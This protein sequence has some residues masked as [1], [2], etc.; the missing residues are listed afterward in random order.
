MRKILFLFVALLL[1]TMVSIAQGSVKGKLMDSSAKQPLGLATITLF[2]AA[3]TAIIT[4]RLSSADG[5]FKVPGL[6]LNLPLRAIISYSGFEASRHEFTLQNSETLDLGT[7]SMTTTSKTL[8]EVLI[9]SERPPVTVKRDT[10]EFNAS[11]FKTLPTSLVEDLL[12]KLPGIQVDGEG[13]ITANGR[14]VNRIMVDGKAFFGD[15]PKMAT[16]NLPANVIDKV[17]VTEDKDEANRNT[18]GDLTNIGQVINLTLKKGVKKGWFG[19]LYGGG[20]TEER[21][22]AGGIAN[23]YRD[24]MQLSLLAFGNNINRSGFSMKEVQ[25]LGGFN[26]SGYNSMMIMNRGGQTG[27]AINGISFGGI[28]QGISR[29]SGAGFNLNHAPNKKKSFFLQYFYGN[30]KNRVEQLNNLQQF[31]NDTVINNR[32]SSFTNRINNNHNI[33]TGAKLK[34]DTLT[35][36]EFRA[37]YSY[38]S[39]NERTDA[40]VS[41]MNNKTGPVSSGVGSQFNR[42]YVNRYNHNLFITRRSKSKKGRSLNLYHFANYNSNLL[43]FITESDIEELVP[44]YEL[45]EF[46]QLRRQNTPVFSTNTNFSYAEPLG[47]KWTWRIN[48]RYEQTR[49]EQEVGIYDKDLAS[50]KY[51]LIN[52]SKSSGFDRKQ[53]MVSGYTG[54]SYK[55]GKANFTV[56]MKA[57]WQFIDN[58]FRNI[59]DPINHRLFNILPSA[60]FQWKQLSAHYSMNVSAPA[61]NYLMPVPDST[62]PFTIRFGNPYLKPVRQHQINA[63]NFNFLQASGTSYNFWI[64]GSIAE[65]DIVMSRTVAANGIQTDRP[66]NA[67][68][69]AQFWGGIGFGKEFKRNLKFIFSF[70]FSPS[71]NFSR[72]SVIFNNQSSVASTIGGGPGLNI[73]LN[74]NDIIEFRPMYSPNIS[75]TTYTDPRFRNI[76]VVTHYMEGELIV[77]WPKKLVWETNLAYRNANQVAPGLPK[78][79]VLWNAAVTLLMLKG[80]VGLLKLS[81]FDVLDRNKGLQRYTNLNQIV[82]NQTNVLQRYGMLTFTYN[83]RNMGAPKKLGGRDRLFWF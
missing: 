69:S 75:R 49:E 82:D 83:I 65:N 62:N 48:A 66:V 60:S 8:D 32:T 44:V 50:T 73:G 14:R 54:L 26:R 39:A 81:V 70:R 22:E 13:N 53:D 25:D 52:F 61:I 45:R 51:E 18:D 15:D 10:I 4:Y 67:G 72:R 3:D 9:I 31:V 71:F 55:I 12:K 36:I 24:T 56:G 28:D 57:L 23:I 47:T 17:Q 58:E 6:P 1:F 33:S 7:I 29:T 46:N 79:N 20:G 80:D 68:S 11:S 40:V 30:T 35:D 77:R 78:T 38:S 43:R 5:T 63:S 59:P 41:L 27:F 19:K 21:Y 42:F 34:P 2:R 64:N 74:W 37:G 16:R 76:R